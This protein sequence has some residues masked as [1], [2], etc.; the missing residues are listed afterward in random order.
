MF[1][2][3]G[4]PLGP[5]GLPQN[6]VFYFE[7]LDFEARIWEK[8]RKERKERKNERT[9]RQKQVPFHNHTHRTFFVIRVRGNP[10]L[11]QS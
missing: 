5:A 11:R 4:A 1:F 2:F 8:E 9:R 10:S 7:S 3:P 6:I